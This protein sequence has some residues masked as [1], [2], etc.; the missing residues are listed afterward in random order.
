MK[1]SLA[2]I[3]AYVRLIETEYN[4]KVG[5]VGIDYLGLLDGPGHNEYEMVSRLATGMKN[6]AKLMNLPVVVLSQTSRQGGSGNSEITLNMGRGSGAIEEGADFVLGLWQRQES[7]GVT[8]T[9][10]L[11]C[12]ILKNRKGPAGSAWNLDLDPKTFRIG[13]DAWEYKPPNK[14]NGGF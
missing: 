6:M 5:V 1:V 8:A 12:K 2:D 4:I 9:R 13:S 14:K 3:P 7:D 10:E 11:I